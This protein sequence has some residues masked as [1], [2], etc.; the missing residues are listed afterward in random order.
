ML[1]LD[2]KLTSAQVKVLLDIYHGGTLR[3]KSA[4]DTEA[5]FTAL[6][7]FKS[8][9][10][11]TIADVLVRKGLVRHYWPDTT[12]VTGVR[13][14]RLTETC[15]AWTCTPRGVAMAEMII[16]TA[17]HIIALAKSREA[18]L[19]HRKLTSKRRRRA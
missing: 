7:P 11:V 9:S 5:M 19:D 15:E 16:E 6:A 13:L 2:F 12:G 1:S 18:L 4:K 8:V 17:G 3:E 10:F 14:W